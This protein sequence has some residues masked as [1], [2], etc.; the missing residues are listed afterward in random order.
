MIGEP[1]ASILLENAGVHLAR[2][3]PP[4]TP[5]PAIIDHAMA[6][7]ELT[8]CAVCRIQARHFGDLGQ[9]VVNYHRKDLPRLEKDPKAYKVIIQAGSQK[10]H[11]FCMITIWRTTSC[12]LLYC[13]KADLCRL[14]RFSR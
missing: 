14:Q 8:A 7:P 1:S 2:L 4:L 3:C 6:F 9:Q 12:L 10:V 5:S 11:N 13:S